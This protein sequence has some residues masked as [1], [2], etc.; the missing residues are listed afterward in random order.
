MEINEIFHLLDVFLVRSGLIIL[1]T[2]ALAK[3]IIVDFRHL[4]KLYNHSRKV[5]PSTKDQKD[6]L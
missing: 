1:A 4:H 3:I 6:N 2:I 5:N